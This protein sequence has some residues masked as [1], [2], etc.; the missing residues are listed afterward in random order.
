MKT[1]T[2]FTSRSVLRLPVLALFFAAVLL[3]AVAPQ[4][5]RG[6]SEKP[7]SANFITRFTSVIEGAI[8]FMSL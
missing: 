8:S 5:A 1:T 7:F 4:P 3:F 6:Q 2:N